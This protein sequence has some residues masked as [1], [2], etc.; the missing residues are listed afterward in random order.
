MLRIGVYLV[1]G[2]LAIF[3]QSTVFSSWPSETLRLELVWI[4]VL[5]LAFS[6]TLAECGGLIVFLGLMEDLAGTPFLGFFVT[7]YFLLASLMRAFIAHMF[8]ET[9]WARL[10]WVGIFTLLAFVV[11]WG[12]LAAIGYGSN[13]R[14]YAL[15]YTLLQGLVNMVLAAIMLPLLDRLD[16]LLY[17]R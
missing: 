4:L 15:T 11:E 13:L 16:H 10:V 3:L 1:L 17:N 12:L 9:L 8:V 6:S 14:G 2:F 7:I 5:S